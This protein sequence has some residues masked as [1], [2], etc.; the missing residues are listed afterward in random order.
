[1]ALDEEKVIQNALAWLPGLFAGE[2]SGH[3]WQHS[4]RV[5]RSAMTICEK[6]GG[7]RFLV[8]L[9]ALLHDADDRKLFATH[10]TLAHARL[11]LTLNGAG[12]AQAEAVCGIIRTVSFSAGLTP[13]SLEG[14]IVQD[15]DRLD[16]IGAIG[17]ARTFAYGGHKGRALCPPGGPAQPGVTDFCDVEGSSIGHFYEKL[18]KLKALMNTATARQLA[19]ARHAYMVGFLR[20]FYGEWN[21]AQ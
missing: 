13:T 10:D 1:M 18:L 16:A 12:A 17:I 14:Q 4:L 15:A 21:G 11:F 6:E 20:Q 5:Y 9:A 19:E 3:D 8:A 2:A 7:D